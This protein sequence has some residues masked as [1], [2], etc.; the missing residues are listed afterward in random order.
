MS[1]E[2]FDGFWLDGCDWPEGGQWSHP[3]PLH[4][5]AQENDIAA[6]QH[7]IAAG[8]PLNDFDILSKTP[9][10][11]AAEAGRLD[12]MR[13]LIEAGADVNAHDAPR[14]GNTVLRAVASNCSYEVAR[15]LIE[16]GADPT[17][18]G[19]MQVTALQ[20]AR[21]RKRPEGV[22]VAQL[23]EA[24]ARNPDRHR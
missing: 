17:I 23:L 8:Q 6:I 14:I 5:A 24:A 11:Y 9:L 19:W 15:L 4:V 22:R 10:H 16:A 3:H 21:A 7:L 20:Q 2:T 13:L 12:V 18:P 1:D